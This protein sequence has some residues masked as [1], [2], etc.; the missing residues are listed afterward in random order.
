MGNK[1]D[2]RLLF[3]NF[4]KYHLLPVALMSEVCEEDI[5]YRHKCDDDKMQKAFTML[6]DYVKENYFGLGVGY[7]VNEFEKSVGIINGE[8]GEIFPSTR[9]KR[10]NTQKAD[11]SPRKFFGDYKQYN[12]RILIKK[13]FMWMYAWVF[14]EDYRP[15][16]TLPDLVRDYNV[17]LNDYPLGWKEVMESLVDECFTRCKTVYDRA[18]GV[19]FYDADFIMLMGWGVVKPKL[20][21]DKDA[22]IS[23]VVEFRKML[24]EILAIV[25]KGVLYDQMPTVDYY[26]DVIDDAIESGEP[27]AVLDMWKILH[28]IGSAIDANKSIADLGMVM[29]GVEMFSY[30]LLGI[31][32]DDLDDKDDRFWIFPTDASLMLCCRFGTD[33]RLEITPFELIFYSDKSGNVKDWCAIN[34]ATVLNSIRAG[35]RVDPKEMTLANFDLDFDEESDDIVSL[36]LLPRESCGIAED[37]PFRKF[38]RIGKESERYKRILDFIIKSNKRPTDVF[39]C[40]DNDW[41]KE[42]VR[43]HNQDTFNICSVL[44]GIDRER[45]Y[46]YDSTKEYYP[47][48]LRLKGRSNE[49]FYFSRISNFELLDLMDMGSQRDKILCINRHKL[50]AAN[51]IKSIDE[52]VYLYRRKLSPTNIIDYV[53]FGSLS[54]SYPIRRFDGKGWIDE[55]YLERLTK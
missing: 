37:F 14:P 11:E 52:Q 12:K 22:D 8:F 20:K 39:F 45:L 27:M 49:E 4:V 48:R 5:A 55:I 18:C 40:N 51:M 1:K 54:K 13:L 38:T 23:S 44:I 43:V 29:D 6:D 36:T 3:N 17:T 46:L 42:H 35:E 33:G 7:F 16:N 26:L 28:D 31:Y 9:S 34:S 41:Y 21:Q 30:E 15:S 50:E 25:P 47:L 10:S 19:E 24:E 2:Y 53:L 32:E